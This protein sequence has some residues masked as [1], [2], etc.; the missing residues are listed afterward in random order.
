MPAVTAF[1]LALLLSP[2]GNAETVF[3]PAGNL[4]E[5]LLADPKRPRFHVSV[6]D[7]DLRDARTTVAAVAYGDEYGLVKWTNRSS[8]KG[9]QL[10]LSGAVFAQFDLGTPSMDL[11]NA[12]YTIG[13]PLAH[14]SGPHSLRLRVYHQSS[15]LGDEYLLRNNTERI[16]LHY[17]A[18]EGLYALDLGP[19]RAYGG[20]EWLFRREPEGLERGMAHLGADFRFARFPLLPPERGAA[21]WVG[22]LDAKGFEHNDWEPGWN[23]VF[24]VEL[25]PSL[26]RRNVDKRLSLLLTWHEGPSPYGQFY[27][28]EVRY[29]GL[30][31]EFDL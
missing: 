18:L 24:G 3:L 15:H 2:P 23:A 27:S 20:G 17:E 4:F 19:F 26:P 6:V 14:R 28:Q 11:V 7:A 29:W 8:R 16:D 12:D 5:P 10:G 22:G 25:R 1:A 30:S 31:L 9:W 13:L 21:Y